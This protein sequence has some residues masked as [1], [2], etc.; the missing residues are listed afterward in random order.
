MTSPTVKAVNIGH[1]DVGQEDHPDVEVWVVNHQVITQGWDGKTPLWEAEGSDQL[2]GILSAHNIP[3][4]E[5][6][7][8]DDD[9]DPHGRF[10]SGRPVLSAS[11]D[12]PTCNHRGIQVYRVVHGG[13]RLKKV[14]PTPHAGLKFRGHGYA[15]WSA[16][17]LNF[18]LL[19]QKHLHWG[20]RGRSVFL[21]TT[22]CV[23]KAIR[24]MAIYHVDGMQDVKLY[25]IDTS[26]A[27]A[28]AAATAT[29]N[30][31]ESSSPIFSVREV[32]AVLGFPC[33]KYSED[34]PLPGRD[35]RGRRGGDP[36]S[37]GFH[38]DDGGGDGDGLLLFL[39]LRLRLG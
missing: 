18:Q 9:S 38:G 19:F 25:K 16:N 14:D 5:Q 30:G 15:T 22:S 8:D 4:S 11:V 10:K 26:A 7:D 23:R 27:A 3:F 36:G 32:A 31:R 24:M 12:V 6:D 28:A 35:T 13:N 29:T 17:P 1:A 37:R 39:L 20:W 2:R 33:K 21:S 34:E